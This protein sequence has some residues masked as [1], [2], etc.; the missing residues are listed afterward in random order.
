MNSFLLFGWAVI[1]FMLAGPLI[2]LAAQFIVVSRRAELS[3]LHV[4]MAR[5]AALVNGVWFAL[6]IWM[7]FAALND[8]ASSPKVILVTT[9]FTLA[10][11]Y[12][13]AASVREMIRTR[14]AREALTIIATRS[15]YSKSQ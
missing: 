8:P 12:V 6:W 15:T 9:A 11:A 5:A 2:T 4:N 13:T 1:V 14:W 7:F 10:G 3:R